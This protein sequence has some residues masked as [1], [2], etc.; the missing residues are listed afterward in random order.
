MAKRY[1]SDK[2]EKKETS[3]QETPQSPFPERDIIEIISD[4]GQ[5]KLNL[6]SILDILAHRIDRQTLRTAILTPGTPE[7]DAY[8]KGLAQGKFDMNKALFENSKL[9]YDT[10]HLALTAEQRHQAISQKLKENFGIDT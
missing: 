5:V 2:E 1:K 7:H 10:S 6:D 3:A 4:C 8:R 9:G